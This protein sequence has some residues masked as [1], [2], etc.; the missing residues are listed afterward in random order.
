MTDRDAS[1]AL[2]GIIGALFVVFLVGAT[3]QVLRL[4]AQ[5]R[6]DGSVPGLGIT[7]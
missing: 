4:R 5:R 7:G 1:P 2:Q 6:R 3:L